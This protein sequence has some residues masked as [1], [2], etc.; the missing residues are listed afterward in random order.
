[1][2]DIALVILIALVALLVGGLVGTQFS[3]T[4]EVEVI[5]IQNVSVPVEVIKTINVTTEVEVDYLSNA[6]EAYLAEVNEDLDKYQELSK[7]ETEDA[8]LVAFD[9]DRKDNKVIT[10]T[11]DVSY[12]ITD[13]LT[14]ERQSVSEKVEVV[15]KEGK[16]PKILIL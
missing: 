10:V 4:E 14:N 13:T 12:K 3:D 16:E 5:K 6:L 1:M 8:Y 2:K 15:F 9:V 7:I 11:F